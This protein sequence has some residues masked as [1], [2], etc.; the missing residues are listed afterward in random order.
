MIC[1]RIAHASSEIRLAELTEEEVFLLTLVALKGVFDDW[2]G[3]HCWEHLYRARKCLWR[4]FA[5]KVHGEVL[6]LVCSFTKRA[7]QL[8]SV[9]CTDTVSHNN[10]TEIHRVCSVCLIC[11]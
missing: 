1:G 2:E 3:W 5:Q 9:Q 10:N 8:K 7:A 6:V 4:G 11:K